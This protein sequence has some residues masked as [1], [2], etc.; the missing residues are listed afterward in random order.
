MEEKNV[1]RCSEI[2]PFYKIFEKMGKIKKESET[3]KHLESAKSELIAALK[4]AIKDVM[5]HLK[6]QK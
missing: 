4:S 1:C 3:V 6:K 2:C 5:K